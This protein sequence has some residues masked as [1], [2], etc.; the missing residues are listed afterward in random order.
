MVI[1]A[2]IWFQFCRSAAELP[3]RTGNEIKNLW[4]THLKKEASEQRDSPVLQQPLATADL[5][6]SAV[7]DL[8]DTIIKLHSGPDGIYSLF[9]NAT[10]IST[11]PI[12]AASSEPSMVNQVVEIGEIT[13]SDQEIANPSSC[14]STSFEA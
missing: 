9:A 7:N 13:P 1:S 14:T 4:N 12:S 8:K 3:G 10:S 2:R 6:A 11:A 5:L